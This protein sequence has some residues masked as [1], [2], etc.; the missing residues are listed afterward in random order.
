MISCPMLLGIAPWWKDGMSYLSRVVIT[1]AHS[2][3]PGKLLMIVFPRQ[4]KKGAGRHLAPNSSCRAP[5]AGF[6]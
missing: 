4:D 5:P 2:L 6:S 3:Q 1:V